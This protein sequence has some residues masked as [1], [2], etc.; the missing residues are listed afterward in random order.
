LDIIFSEIIRK[1][2]Y[3]SLFLIYEQKKQNLESICQGLLSLGFS[4][5]KAFMNLLMASCSY[6]EAKSVVELTASRHY[7]YHYSNIS[8]VSDKLCKDEE[9]YGKVSGTL[10]YYFVPTCHVPV[11]KTASRVMYHSFSQDMCMIYKSA[12]ACLPDKVY[13]H[14]ANGLGAGIVEGHKLGF[15]HLHAPKDWALPT[16]IEV[17]AP[18]GNATDLVVKQLNALISGDRLPFGKTLC[19]NNVGIFVS[20]LNIEKGLPKRGGQKC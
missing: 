15:T 2:R 18:E 3:F 17:V 7:H 16:A 20:L 10:L 4:R 6:L 1:D 9:K 12:P 14:Q 5:V 11:S 19:I 8:K 13:G